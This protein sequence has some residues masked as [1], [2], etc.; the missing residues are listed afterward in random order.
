MSE[1]RQSSAIGGILIG[2]LSAAL[3]SPAAALD[4]DQAF[5]RTAD[6]AELEWGPCPEF[7]PAGCAIAVLQG[8]PAEPNADVFFRLPAGATVPLHRHASAE[9][10]VLVS[11]EM[12]VRYEGQEAVV[13]KAGTYAYG[14]PRLPHDATCRSATDC[15]LFIAFEEPV[16]AV[17]V[18]E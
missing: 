8:N 18:E 2:L 10:M 3:M 11:G 5:I 15:V 12:Q 4:E 7:M 6:S 9:R 13:L 14:P 17:A 1:P 16:D